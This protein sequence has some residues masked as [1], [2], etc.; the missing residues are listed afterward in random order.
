[1]DPDDLATHAAYAD[2]LSDAGDPRGEFIQVQLALED[3][4]LKPAERNK[5]QKREQA[6]LKKHQR[7]WLGD[8]APHLLRGTEADALTTFR[9]CFRP[10]WLDSL[11]LGSRLSLSL[12]RLLAQAPQLRLLRRL[13]IP[14]DPLLRPTSEEAD[15]DELAEHYYIP[16]ESDAIPEEAL[17][18]PALFPLTRS[19]NL[20]NLRV[21]QLG[22]PGSSN[23]EKGWYICR[24]AGFAAAGLVKL[25]P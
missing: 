24:F 21:L 25:M 8:L 2:L 14:V 5:L 3:E 10:G 12:P 19:T 18:H 11:E 20:G 7:D 15:Q 23:D 16:D 1:E 13:E 6:L 22:D 4:K 17:Y 9:V